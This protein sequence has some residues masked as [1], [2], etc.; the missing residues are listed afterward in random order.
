MTV[1][2]AVERDL[3]A[4][5]RVA[6]EVADSGVAASALALAAE[7][8]S[9]NNSA[10]SKSMCAKALADAM[11]TL[12]EWSPPAQKKDGVDE[13]RDR[14]NAQRATRKAAT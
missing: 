1:V 9:P 11:K 5:R 2:E 14:R 12:R 13:L 3:D 10:T 7:L 8:D 6:P 4:I